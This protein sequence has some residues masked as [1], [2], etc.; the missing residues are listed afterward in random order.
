MKD[1]DLIVRNFDIQVGIFG[2]LTTSE[3]SQPL[4]AAGRIIET[5]NE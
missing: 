2:V 3:A 4:N 5:H 1:V